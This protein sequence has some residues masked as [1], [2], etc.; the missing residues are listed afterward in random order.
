MA[1]MLRHVVLFKWNDTLPDGH[2]EAV[3]AAL[4][5]LPPA[6]PQIVTFVHGAN[7]GLNPGTWDYAVVADFASPADQAAY[8]DH[9]QHQ[10]FIA[11]YLNGF[12]VERAAVQ[13][14]LP[15]QVGE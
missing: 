8:R 11:D 6:I 4:D 10:E 9:P 14:E 1:S 3:A 12:V 13:F 7:L 15:E 5:A 2:V